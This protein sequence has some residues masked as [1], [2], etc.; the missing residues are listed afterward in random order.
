MQNSPLVSVITPTYNH[1]NYIAECIESVQNQTYTNWEMIIINDGSNDETEKIIKK[2]Q[3]ED[4]RIKYFFQNNIGVFRLHE[5]YNFALQQSSGKYVSILEGDDIWES[6]KLKKQILSLENNENAVLSWGKAYNTTLD[7]NQILKIVP[8]FTSQKF[9]N[10]PLLSCIELLYFNYCIPALTITIRKQELASIG[11]FQK[12]KDLPAVDFPTVLALSSIGVFS[13]EDSILGRQRRY[14]NQ[15]TKKFTVE[16]SLASI[17]IIQNHFKTLNQSIKDS[18]NFN[19]NDLESYFKN[20]L[21]K[22]YFIAGKSALKRKEFSTAQVNFKTALFLKADPLILFRT[23]AL[24][25]YFL[26]IFK[27]TI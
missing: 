9:K 20:Y 24:V 26:S 16:M 7:T 13:F 5:T 23:K 27:L 10:T 15:T 12:H 8:N 11:G 19:Q 6:N 2:Y 25:G 1:Q 3:Q 4:S 14:P 22:S 17:D 21:L 18:L